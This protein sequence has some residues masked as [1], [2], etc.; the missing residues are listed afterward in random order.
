MTLKRVLLNEK[1]M[2]HFFCVATSGSNVGAQL[3][4]KEKIANNLHDNN[5]G[6]VGSF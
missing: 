6:N 4:S 2:Y 1:H 5:S 3:V